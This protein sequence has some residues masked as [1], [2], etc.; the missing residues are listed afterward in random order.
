MYWKAAVRS[1]QS[2]LQ[3]EQPQLSQPFLIGEVFQP[4]DHLCS[5]PL[6]PFQEVR[7]CPVLRAPELDTGLQM[8]SPQ[9][10]TEGQSHLPR[11]AGHTAFDAAREAVGLLGCERALVAHVQLFTHQCPQVLL[12]RAALKPFIPHPVLILG[13]ALTHVQGLALGLVGPHEV[14]MHPLLELVQVPLDGILSL[15][16]ANCTTQLGV[17]CE[18]AES[19]LDLAVCVRIGV[20]QCDGLYVLNNR[21]VLKCGRGLF[22]IVKVFDV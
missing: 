12:S 17:I 3:A 15:R 7:V 19:A 6:D 18:L 9:S 20:N 8:G 16:C 1:P 2:L 13:V 14:H 5:P 10:R 11:P 22:C 4:S 21:M